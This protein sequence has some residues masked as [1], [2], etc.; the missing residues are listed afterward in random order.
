MADHIVHIDQDASGNWSINPYDVPNVKGKQTIEW[1]TNTSGHDI[2]V[3]FTD[4][5]IAPKKIKVTGTGKVIDNPA[6]QEYFYSVT[7]DGKPIP[8]KLMS[9]PG[10]IIE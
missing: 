8:M 4:P 6:K 3:I 9:A 7:V 1:T 2:E 5:V 10:I